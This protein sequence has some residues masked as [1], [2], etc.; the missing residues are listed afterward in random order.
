MNMP[1]EFGMAL[2]PAIT[3]QW[4]HR[5][6]VFFVSNTKWQKYIS[7]LSGLDPFIHGED[8]SAVLRQMYEW[9]MSVAPP[10]Q[11]RKR[12]AICDVVEQFRGFKRMLSRVHGEEA[13]GKPS[14]DQAQEVMYRICGN[15]G[16]WDWRKNRAGK[17]EFPEKPL[18]FKN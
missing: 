10:N 6:C 2:Y 5:R 11:V 14:H 18:R 16:L 1:L 17:R 4:E 9:L 13:G 8:P 3:T 15:I 7:D 12:L